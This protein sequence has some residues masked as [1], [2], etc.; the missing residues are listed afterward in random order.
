MTIALHDVSRWLNCQA[1]SFAE[2]ISSFLKRYG[3][4]LNVNDEYVKK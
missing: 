3:K 2:G 4:S 1:D